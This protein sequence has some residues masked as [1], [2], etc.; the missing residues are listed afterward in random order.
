[1]M[2]TKE[3]LKLCVRYFSAYEGLTDLR[4]VERHTS[5]EKLQNKRKRQSSTERRERRRAEGG[6][7]NN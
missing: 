4:M 7:Y 5:L 1:M 6:I 2:L 3:L